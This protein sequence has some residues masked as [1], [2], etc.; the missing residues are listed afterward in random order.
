MRTPVHRR[1]S[2]TTICTPR[3]R[4]DAY[5]ARTLAVGLLAW[6]VPLLAVALLTGG[7][8]VVTQ[9][10]VSFSGTA[11]VTFGG[12]YAVLAFVAQRAV[13]V[14]GWLS[15]GE[16]IRGPGLAESTPGPLIMVV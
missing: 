8:S 10:G 15:L 7:G 11:M 13:E 5:A 1:S 3:A 12:A 4:R 9:M 16:M 14:Y 6:G 2:R